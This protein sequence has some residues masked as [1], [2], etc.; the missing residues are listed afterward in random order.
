[1]ASTI[2]ARRRPLRLLHLLSLAGTLWWQSKCP[3]TSQLATIVTASASYT[4]SGI[5]AHARLVLWGTTWM[6]GVVL[7][8]W[9]DGDGDVKSWRYKLRIS[10]SHVNYLML[11]QDT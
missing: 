11:N 2:H 3:Q 7:L 1:M 5:I 6:V 8:S 4:I 10:I 9:D